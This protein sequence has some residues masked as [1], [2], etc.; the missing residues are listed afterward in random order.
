MKGIDVSNHNGSINFYKVKED[1]IQC[2]YI[3]A[4]E[5]TTYKDSYLEEHYEGARSSGLNIGF[6]H[7]LVGSSSPETQAENF[8]EKISN[9]ENNLKPC[10]DI[11]RN[12]FDVMDYALRFIKRFE[13]LCDFKLC[14]YA[15]PY[16]INDNLDNRLNEYPLWVAHYGVDVPMSNNVWGRDY[17]GHQY[18]EAGS[19]SGIK[20]NVDLNN[21]N[22]EILINSTI[23]EYISCDMDTYEENI[24]SKLQQELN[25]QGFRDRNGNKLIIDGIPGALTL[26][27]CPLVQQGA[28]G[29]ITK[30]IQLRID[31]NADGIFG[32]ETKNAV[33]NFQ[34]NNGLIADGIV[35]ENTW[36]K[37]LNL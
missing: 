16:F 36:R 34:S 2:V 21:F 4:T 13:E 7:F 20:G 35:G 15:S 28:M 19:I 23:Q 31:V 37:L 5:G 18:T 9:K 1:G 14:I 30:W 24:Y 25:E 3:K 8:Y 6:Y 12:D 27:A 17:A 32:Q 22:D 26:S 10:L 33:M 29:D 11:E